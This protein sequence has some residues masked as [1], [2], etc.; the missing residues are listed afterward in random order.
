[1]TNFDYAAGLLLLLSGLFGFVRGATREITTVVA[2]VVGAVLAVVALPLTRPLTLHLVHTEWLATAAA[3]LVTFVLVYALI[4]LAGGVLT[5]GVRQTSLSGLDRLLGFGV[6]LVR[7]VVLLGGF[8]LLLDAATPPERMPTWVTQAKLYPLASAAGDAL[9]AFAPQGLEVAHEV[10][11][12]LT[13]EVA[14]DSPGAPPPDT[15]PRRRRRRPA[16]AAT[17][18]SRTLDHL[19]EESR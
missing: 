18:Q 5:R 16:G 7:A 11:P 4:R 2:L 19:V 15:P 17:E 3:V 9:R 8:V 1:M 6:G 14:G 10:A 12:D 13:T